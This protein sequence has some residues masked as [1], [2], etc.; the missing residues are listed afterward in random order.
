ML[1][2]TWTPAGWV[3]RLLVLLVVFLGFVLQMARG[4]C[5]TP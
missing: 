1:T 3:A 4:E 2:K 5:P